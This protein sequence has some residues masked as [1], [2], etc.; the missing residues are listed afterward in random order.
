M[1]Q[2]FGEILLPPMGTMD[3]DSVPPA[4]ITSAP[5][6]RMRSAAM[7]MACRPEEQKRL[8]VMAE[9]PRAGPLAETRC[10]PRSCPV[11]LR[12]WHTQEPHHQYF[13]DRAREPARALP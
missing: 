1:S 5:P 2:G 11:R 7:A 10:A 9:V 12:A 6:E 8:I 4:T 13:S 3:M